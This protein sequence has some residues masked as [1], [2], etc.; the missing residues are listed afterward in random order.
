M[1]ETTPP[2]QAPDQ[3]IDEGALR[4]RFVRASGPGGQN[5]NKVATAV[6]LHV[7]LSDLGLAPEVLARLRQHAG[8]RV[9]TAGELVIAAQRFRTQERNRADALERL[10]E[11]IARARVVPKARKATKPTRAAKERRL[12]TKTLRAKTKQLRGRAHTDD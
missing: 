11:M 7:T 2:P 10:G 4:F 9:N 6:Q 8:K 12:Q 5:V 1:S 3:Q